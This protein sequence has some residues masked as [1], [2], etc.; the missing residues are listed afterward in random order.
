MICDT[1]CPGTASTKSNVIWIAAKSRN[2]LL[3]PVQDFL[4]V[5]EAIVRKYFIAV[6]HESVWTNAIV[7]A[8]HHDAVAAVYNQ[9]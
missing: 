3:H 5:T 9:T 6:R 4:L 8:H 1:G 2:M 7:E